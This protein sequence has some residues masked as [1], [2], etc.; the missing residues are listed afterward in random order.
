MFFGLCVGS[1]KDCS[2]STQC[3]I[4]SKT[5]C[6]SDYT[7]S[8]AQ[9][10]GAHFHIRFKNHSR[11]GF[12]LSLGKMVCTGAKNEKD[13]RLAARKYAK[14]VMK[15]GY[16]VTFHDF[17]IQNIVGS[18]DVQFNIGLE[19]LNIKHS[20]FTRYEPELFPGLIYKMKSPKVVLLIFV[21]GKVIHLFRNHVHEPE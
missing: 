7:N 6:C 14:I 10:H 1:Q 19:G 15:L 11:S 21:S 20:L 13:S 4:Q 17:K 18:C 12:L 5:L 16:N 3:R 9:N 2:T 8:G